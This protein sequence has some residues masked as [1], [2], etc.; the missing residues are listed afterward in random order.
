MTTFQTPLT[1]HAAL[2]STLNL[3]RFADALLVFCKV[4]IGVTACICIPFLCIRF[5]T[6]A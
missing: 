6:R 2:N 4:A 5:S 3:A 1:T